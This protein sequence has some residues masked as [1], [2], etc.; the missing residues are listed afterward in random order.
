MTVF[1]V[2]PSRTATSLFVRPAGQQPDNLKLSVGKPQVRE[3]RWPGALR[4]GGWRLTQRPEVVAHLGD[5]GLPGPAGAYGD[6][7]VERAGAERGRISS[8]TA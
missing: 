3:R 8:T 7:V 1:G 4:L 2:R 5:R 6:R